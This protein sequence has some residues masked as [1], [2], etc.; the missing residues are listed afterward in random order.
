M[1][2]TSIVK[3]KN[4]KRTWYLIDATGVRLGKLASFVSKLLQG[5][6]KVY[7]TSNVDCG[8]YVIVINSKDIDYFPKR[9]ERKIYWRHSGYPGGLK[10]MTLGEM[11]KRKPNEVIKKAIVGMMPKT[12]LSKSMIKKLYIYSGCDY[13][14]KS[15]KPKLIKIKKD[16]KE[17]K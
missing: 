2:K 8:D 14:Q 15:C 13:K 5:K 11:M 9:A 10:K 3:P 17:K 6:N 4:V 1:M 16:G 7:Y 12:K